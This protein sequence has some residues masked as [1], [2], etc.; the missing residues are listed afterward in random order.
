MIQI[1]TILLMFV[2]TINVLA[3]QD[4]AEKLVSSKKKA[5]MT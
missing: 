5:D 4:D 1:L 3:V 2:I